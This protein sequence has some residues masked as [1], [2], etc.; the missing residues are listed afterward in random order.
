MNNNIF[1]KFLV[2]VNFF[3]YVI[4]F[5]LAIVILNFLILN[6][7]PENA[8]HL[9][10]NLVDLS[11][12]WF[13]MT[14]IVIIGPAFETVFFQMLPI[15]V[16]R[17]FILKES[18]AFIISILVSALL[19]ALAHGIYSKY[20][21]FYAFG[22]GFVLAVSYNLSYYRREYPFFSVF[23]IHALWNFLVLI[24]IKTNNIHILLK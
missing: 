21:I 4:I 24:L 1:F 10:D 5:F 23:I 8:L 13:G 3:I 12:S 17:E 15:S 19:F 11:Y 7:I 18:S 16:T 22:G 6:I 2:K 14:L 20:Y 9:P